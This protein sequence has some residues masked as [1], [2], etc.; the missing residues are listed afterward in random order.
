MKFKRLYL[1]FLSL[2]MLLS[3]N[4]SEEEYNRLAQEEYERKAEIL[5]KERREICLKEK[6]IRAE[7]LADSIIRQLKLNP[8]KEDQYRPTIP[9]RPDFVKTD[10]TTVN[11][12]Q[13]VKPILKSSSDNR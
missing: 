7:I 12:K 4:I 3:C 13:S 10:S 8:L 1:I 11:S 9:A 5:R 2:S 6:L